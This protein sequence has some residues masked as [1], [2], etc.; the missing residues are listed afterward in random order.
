MHIKNIKLNTKLITIMLLVSLVPLTLV[1]VWSEQQA[2]HALLSGSYQ[3]LTS[4]RTLKAHQIENYF[5]GL[6]K[7]LTVLGDTVGTVRQSAFTNLEIIADLK[8][9]KLQFFLEDHFDNMTVLAESVEAQELYD[10]LVAYHRDTGVAADGP[11]D[12]TNAQYNE[13]YHQYGDHIIKNAEHWGFKDVLMICAEHGHVMFSTDRKPDMGTNLRSGPYKDSVLRRLWDKVKQHK[14][15]SVVDVELYQANGGK[16]AAYAGVPLFEN[17]ELRGVMAVEISLESINAIMSEREGL[18]KT[19]E[20][21][22]I[23]PDHLMRSDSYLDPQS[24]SVLASFKNPEKGKV[25]TEAA[26]KVLKGEDGEKVIID[27]NGNLV[28][29]QWS[30]MRIGKDLNWGFIAE[31]DVAEAFNPVDLEGQEFFAKYKENYGHYDLFLVDHNGYIF[32]S[33]AKESDYQ[34]NIVTGKYSG[35]NLGELVREVMKSKRFGISDFAPYAPSNGEPAAF[36]AMPIMHAGEVEMVAAIQVETTGINKIMQ[37]RDGM[38]E[39][40]ETYLVGK[41][42]RMRSDSFLD[43]EG[44]NMKASFAGTVERNGV[45]TDAVRNAMAGKTDTGIIIDYNGNPVLSSYQP[46]DIG[47]TQWAVIAEID[48]AEV[49]QPVEKLIRD[50][51]IVGMGFAIMVVA[52]AYFFARSITRPIR[53][54]VDIA[55]ALAAGDLTVEVKSTSTDETGQLLSAMQSLVEKLKSIIG[56]VRSGADSLASASQE[57]SATAQTISQGATEQAASVEETTASVE[58]LN[59]SVQQNTENARVTDGM[60]SK[61]SA[62]ASQGGEAVNRTVQAMKQIADKIKLIEDIAYKTNLLSL[63]A[64]IEAARAGD[65]GKGFTVVAAE[66]RKLAENSRSTAQ[67]INELATNSVSV[68]E[69]AGQLLEAI[70]PSIA[71]TADL[72]QE[73]AAASEEQSAGVGQI[74]SAMTQLDS[75]T[76][77]NASASE[78]LAATAEELSGQAESLQH[79]VA[80]FKLL[81]QGAGLNSRHREML[82]SQS[83]SPSSKTVAQEHGNEEPLFNEDDFERF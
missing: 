15:Q 79:A 62:E 70:V 32:Y 17:G 81:S 49:M 56:Q 75:A 25:E 4:M 34:T 51:V 53:R 74:N 31:I 28:L 59:A 54:T 71:K 68:A 63:N 82:G 40:G 52:I 11:Y 65:H 35:S 19:G 26:E 36:A 72:V 1:A 2:S 37:M 50:I 24:H 58:Q 44:H 6:Q 22:L 41:D 21:Y 47:S 7:E 42:K 67:E 64:A 14:E 77:Q 48:E 13:I 29:S 60:A 57:V 73:I 20:T 3:Q 43:P 80:F 61:A 18:G 39:T 5:A 38:G 76:Q 30:P 8:K 9:E 16:P 12:V 45:D 78:E 66:V 83:A 23:G 33:V 69:E 55:N 46:I 27:Y 10:H